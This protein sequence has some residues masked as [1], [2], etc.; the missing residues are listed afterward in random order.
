MFVVS[1]NTQDV[2]LEIFN[3]IKHQDDVTLM[4]LLDPQGPLAC[5]YDLWGWPAIELYV[6]W[7]EVVFWPKLAQ[8]GN[9]VIA[10]WGSLEHGVQLEMRSN[11]KGWQLYDATPRIDGHSPLNPALKLA[12]T[13]GMR[14]PWRSPPQDD[15]EALL[16]E[17]GTDRLMGP[18]ALVSRVLLW[19]LAVKYLQLPPLTPRAWAA[20]MEYQLISRNEPERAAEHAAQC[21]GAS[22]RE[23]ERAIFLLEAG[24]RLH[25]G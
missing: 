12:E 17:R 19:R 20:A 24:W 13:G 2:V 8:N 16:R 5:A 25:G 6:T 4:P 14:L 11:E 3:A 15:V 9:V 1:A 18:T 7:G 21:Y 23:L 22:R 10:S